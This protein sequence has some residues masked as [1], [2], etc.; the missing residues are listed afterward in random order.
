MGEGTDKFK[1]NF[2]DVPD[3]RLSSEVEGQVAFIY[4]R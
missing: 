4:V 1:L 3:D 2:G